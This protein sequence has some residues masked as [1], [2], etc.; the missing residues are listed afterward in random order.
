[1]IN[2][3]FSLDLSN[4]LDAIWKDHKFI[5]YLKSVKYVQHTLTT[6]SVCK[7]NFLAC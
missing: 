1:M 3:N 6:Y 2:S 7:Q 5:I 4:P